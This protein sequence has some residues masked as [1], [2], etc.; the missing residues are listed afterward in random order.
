MGP[1]QCVGSDDNSFGFDGYLSKK[2]HSGAE[3]YGKPWKVGDVIGCFL[4][5]NDR[6]VSFSLNGELLL[7]PSGAEMAFD[8][9]TIGDGFVPSFSLGPGQRARL[10][11]GQDAN[12]LK[13]FTTCGL[14]EGYE[15]FCVNMY[16]RLPLWYL[17]PSLPRHH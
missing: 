2:W 15:P 9:I 6:T 1:L 17:P 5:L 11:Y 14:Q 12:S 13:F 16:R 4:D 7:D 8:N 10:N 3:H